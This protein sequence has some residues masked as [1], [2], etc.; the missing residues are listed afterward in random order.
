MGYNHPTTHREQH[1]LYLLLLCLSKHSDMAGCHG[2]FLHAACSFGLDC[3]C[4]DKERC[5]GM[6]MAQLSS[7]LRKI[8]Q[9]P[10][11]PGSLGHG[12]PSGTPVK[13]ISKC[14]QQL[15]ALS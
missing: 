13:M 12:F 8:F 11:S 7:G 1:Q 15:H 14:L 10:S 5:C 3:L 4:G 2:L 6:T 9:G